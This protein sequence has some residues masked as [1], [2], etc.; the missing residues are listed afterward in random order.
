MTVKSRKYESD[1]ILM[2]VTLNT[3]RDDQN[4]FED[5]DAHICENITLVS[6]KSELKRLRELQDRMYLNKYSD[7]EKKKATEE[8]WKTLTLICLDSFLDAKEQVDE[9]T[10]TAGYRFGEKVEL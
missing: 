5:P 4:K 7:E 6:D 1:R 9:I 2:N 10:G 3:Y 8:F